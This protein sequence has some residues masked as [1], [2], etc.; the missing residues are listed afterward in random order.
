[1]HHWYSALQE[2]AEQ[3]RSLSGAGAGGGDAAQQL[4]VRAARSYRS[5]LTTVLRCGLELPFEADL[6]NNG[7]LLVQG[8]AEASS[9][10]LAWVDDVMAG[11][12]DWDDLEEEV[13]RGCCFEYLLGGEGTR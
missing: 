4:L 3:L 7:G 1:M 5:L 8:R 6:L 2:A 9:H 12:G 13:G 11:V 10:L